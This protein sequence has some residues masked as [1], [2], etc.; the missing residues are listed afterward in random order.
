LRPYQN[1]FFLKKKSY[2]DWNQKVLVFER[3][4]MIDQ[5]DLICMSI[6]SVF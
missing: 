5:C 6:Q 1:V 4:L 2:K 3:P